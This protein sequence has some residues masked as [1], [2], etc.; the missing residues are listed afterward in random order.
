MRRLSPISWA[1][2][3]VGLAFLGLGV[4]YFAYTAPDLPSFIPGHVDRALHA[5]HYTKRGVA[6][7]VI[8]ALAFLGA[9]LVTW[10][11][12]SPSAGEPPV[13]DAGS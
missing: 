9:F 10:K 8:A 13:V 4:I 3:V 5:R 7:I 2:I 11:R 1:L 6:G 12:P